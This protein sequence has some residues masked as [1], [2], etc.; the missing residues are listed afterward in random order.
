MLAVIVV[1][2][3]VVTDAATGAAIDAAIDV[4][5]GAVIAVVIGK[6]QLSREGER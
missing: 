2:I 6:D 3:G 5:T 1:S 4:V